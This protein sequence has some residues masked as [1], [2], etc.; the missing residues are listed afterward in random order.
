VK[1]FSVLFAL[2]VAF[3]WATSPVTAQCR[4]GKCLLPSV[5]APLYVPSQIVPANVAPE[6]VKWWALNSE[7]GVVALL[8]GD[9]FLGKLDLYD[10]TWT[11]EG[12]EVKNLR[13]M[14]G[15][16]NPASA[17]KIAAS[18]LI[19]AKPAV[20]CNG[21]DCD[22]TNC[23]G[24]TC[25]CKPT[26]TIQTSVVADKKEMEP[27][28]NGPPVVFQGGVD[29]TQIR[30]DGDHYLCN[31]KQCTRAE[32][33]NS[34]AAASS[35]PDDSGSVRLTVIGGAAIRQQVL[36]DIDSKPEFGAFKGKFVLASFPADHWRIRDGGFK[37]PA[38][39]ND[40]MI[41][42]QRPDG[43]VLWRQEGYAGGSVKLASALRDKVPG[44][45][46]LKDPNP[47]NVPLVRPIEPMTPLKNSNLL[48]WLVGGVALVGSFLYARRA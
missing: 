22:C 11:P 32:A 23:E 48:W 33:M 47:D 21:T 28:D 36:A 10:G 2:V 31:G 4:N 27:R 6:S 9:K 42:A 43:T 29:F 5:S 35:V 7:P 45:D 12:G 24:P 17:D 8:A 39:P 16:I 44:Y 34:L 20:R 1:R 13:E 14:S 26:R 30:S 37:V 40:V 18:K 38:N 25:K 19:G 46:P 3:L 41:Y 15:R